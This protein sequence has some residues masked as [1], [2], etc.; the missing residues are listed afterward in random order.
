MLSFCQ[1]NIDVLLTAA[2]SGTPS[3][4]RG[5]L[6]VSNS[7]RTA[8]PEKHGIVSVTLLRQAGCAHQ[9]TVVLEGRQGG[10]RGNHSACTAGASHLEDLKPCCNSVQGLCLETVFKQRKT[11]KKR[12]LLLPTFKES[13]NHLLFL[14]VLEF[15]ALLFI[16]QFSFQEFLF[17]SEIN[18]VVQH[19]SLCILIHN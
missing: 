13:S 10:R 8:W 12:H 19:I 18:Y 15:N 2:H 9:A 3:W 6:A 16:Q 14:F 4:L 1:A 11:K 17:I 5:N 7:W